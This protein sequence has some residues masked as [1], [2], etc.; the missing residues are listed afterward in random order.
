MSIQLSISGDDTF[1][2]PEVIEGPFNASIQGSFS[3]TTVTVQRSTN[4]TD[5]YD[6][7]TFT[8]AGEW[9]GFEPERLH[10]R[11]GVKAGE[12]SAGP[13]LVRIGANRRNSI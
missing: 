7:D 5:W 10:Y 9:P 3:G 1:T 4:K 13:V 6:V 8:T 2:D 12:Y 11:I